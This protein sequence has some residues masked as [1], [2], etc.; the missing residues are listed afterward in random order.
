[1]CVG[2]VPSLLRE[3]LAL[4]ERHGLTLAAL[5]DELCWTLAYLSEVL[6]E[7]DPLPKLRLIRD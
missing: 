7:A 5:A 1:M 3:G 2:E 4:A 6:G